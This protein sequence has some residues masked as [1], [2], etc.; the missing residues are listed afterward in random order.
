MGKEL[1]EDDTSVD[2]T[3]TGEKLKLDTEDRPYVSAVLHDADN[4]ADFV[5]E[6]HYK[7]SSTDSEWHNLADNDATTGFRFEGRVPERYVR[8]R[9]D[10]NS[11]GS[12]TGVLS[13]N[14]TKG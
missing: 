11:A 7:D 1:Y 6:A 9:L 2:I 4:S 3:S 13:I 12:G 8:V 5:V 14:A 10:A